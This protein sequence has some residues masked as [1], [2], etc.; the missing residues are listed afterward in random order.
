MVW[1][2]ISYY[3]QTQLHIFKSRQKINAAVYTTTVINTYFSSARRLH[4][5]FF[6]HWLEDHYYQLMQDNAA[7]HTAQYTL[8]TLLMMNINILKNWPANS[9]DLTPSEN[10]WSWMARKV[11][12][13]TPRTTETLAQWA[14]H[15]WNKIDANM[16]R[17]L[18]LSVPVRLLKCLANFGHS[19]KY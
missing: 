15:Y 8:E 16:R 7:P 1:G 19:I 14:R 11:T 13:H 2:A 4:P 6:K 10:V 9:P 18:I 3:G 12:M 5:Q 17:A